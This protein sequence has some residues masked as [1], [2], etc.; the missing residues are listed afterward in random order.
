M[1]ARTKEQILHWCGYG[2]IP[3]NA[4]LP[5][6][7]EAHQQLPDI[8]TL[9]TIILAAPKSIEEEQQR[10]DY[11]TSL[12]EDAWVRDEGWWKYRDAT[13]DGLRRAIAWRGICA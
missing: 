3:V 7:I 10:L 8:Y 13:L 1:N 2:V 5:A 6:A 9:R 11:L 12:P 4:N